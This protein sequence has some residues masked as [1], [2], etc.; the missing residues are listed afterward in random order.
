[1]AHGDGRTREDF[2]ALGAFRGDAQRLYA[3]TRGRDWDIQLWD[4]IAAASPPPEISPIDQ[5]EGW[6]RAWLY[7]SRWAGTVGRR[8]AYT[9][10]A[11]RAGIGPLLDATRDRIVEIAVGWRWP[12]I[13]D[14][15]ALDDER[16]ETT[17]AIFEAAEHVSRKVVRHFADYLADLERDRAWTLALTLELEGR[18]QL[19][20]VF[21]EVSEYDGAER[22]LIAPTQ[23]YADEFG[24][25]IPQARLKRIVDEWCEFFEASSTPIR[26]LD[27][28]S[29]APKRL[30][31]ALRGQTQLR[32][33]EIK[34]G[35]YEDISAVSRMPDLWTLR[36]GGASGLRT[37]PRFVRQRRSGC[38]LWRTAVGSRIF[39]RW[40]NSSRWRSSA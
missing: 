40:P 13:S 25:P 7:C 31:A 3:A 23:L 1:M 6:A 8:P 28:S 22:I 4:W 37:S 12:E 35:D 18:G 38:L 19:P 34:W 21:T 11:Q 20:R 5:I 39:R 16:L 30:V 26:Y 15:S 29:R 32:G 10:H 2:A 24:R 33:L 9:Y 36:L 27:I 17:Y 14:M